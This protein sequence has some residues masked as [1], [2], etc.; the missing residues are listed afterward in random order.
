LCK[1][2]IVAWEED[3]RGDAGQSGELL[4]LTPV[5]LTLKKGTPTGQEAE[6]AFV[7]AA[8]FA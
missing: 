1:S 2:Q 3:G 7:R 4:K 6:D 5:Y 8:T